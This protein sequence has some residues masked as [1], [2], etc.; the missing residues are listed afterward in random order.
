MGMTLNEIARIIGGT[1]IGRDDIIINN[2]MAIEDAREG[3]ITFIANAK[4]VKKL[5]MTQASA[6]IAPPQTAAEGKT[7]VIVVDPYAAFGKLLA[8]FYPWE[9][10]QKGISPD[11]YIEEGAIV[12]PE[13]NIFPK[14]FISRGTKV[15]RGAFIYPGVYI[16]RNVSIG[17]NSVIYANVTIY[18]SCII[19]KR[20]ILHSGVI[21]GADGFG[22][23]DPGKS[24]SKIPQ[25]GIVQIDDDVEIGANTT[26][27]RATLGK[28]WLGRN[29]KIDN[30]VQIAHNVVIGENSVIAAQ[31]GISG[32]TK[33]GKSV[34][35]GGQVGIVGHISIGDH[36]MIGASSNI[37]KD[38]PAGQIGGGSPFL[39][40]KEWLRVESSKVK[41]PE[42]RVKLQRLIKY[43]EQLE[44]KINKTGKE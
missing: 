9:H 26:I 42:I 35:I 22:F 21:V 36:V 10:G 18:H 38:I 14:A 15:E 8:L 4:Y 39:P 2:I 25:V 6:I 37:H 23:A 1:V 5:K 17:E 43:V 34:I 19:G 11:A 40:S 13:A 33:I 44:A 32:S 16:G 20:V 7:L 12:S 28:T 30:L 27:D 3:D 24:N 31:T 41:L 29:V